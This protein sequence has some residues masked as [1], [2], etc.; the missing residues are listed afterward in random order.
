MAEEVVR[1]KAVLDLTDLQAQLQEAKA[2]LAGALSD[3]GSVSGLPSM[4]S[5]GPAMLAAV[6]G[7][8]SA[9]GKTVHDFSA[10]VMAG[11]A[12]AGA[13]GVAAAGAWMH[14]LPSTPSGEH[15]QYV[16]GQATSPVMHFSGQH[17]IDRVGREAQIRAREDFVRGVVMKNDVAA[18]G[19]GMALGAALGVAGAAV[20]GPVGAI[21][22]YVLGD[23][24]GRKVVGGATDLL[25][26]EERFRQHFMMRDVLDSSINFGGTSAAMSGGVLKP[27]V[28]AALASRLTRRAYET[29][30]IDAGDS[31]T[32]AS[33]AGRSGLLSGA[34]AGANSTGD[35]VE[36]I[37]KRLAELEQRVV[38][39]KRATGS[40]TEGA[41]R[42]IGQGVD[43]GMS[44]AQAEVFAREAPILGRSAGVSARFVTDLSR[45]GSESFRQVGL[46]G[47]A[48]ARS[49]EG[50]LLAARSL[51]DSG[52]YSSEQ[53]MRMGGVEGIAQE[54][55]QKQ[56]G[57]FASDFGGALMIAAG[58]QP[59]LMSQYVSGAVSDREITK[60]A[61]GKLQGAT[62]NEQ[63]RIRMEA[64][65][66]LGQLN[67]I[68]TESILSRQT[69]NKFLT[70]NPKTPVTKE[71]FTAWAYSKGHTAEQSETMYS[72]VIELQ[73]NPDKLT[74][75][76]E[77]HEKEFRTTTKAVEAELAGEELRHDKRREMLENIPGANALRTAR[78]FWFGK[79]ESAAQIET[80]SMS[81]EREYNRRMAEAGD[82]ADRETQN[83]AIVD[84]TKR[85]A[86]E[87][88]QARY[89]A[90]GV[91]ADVGTWLGGADDWFFK[92]MMG[93][94]LTQQ[95]AMNKL[96]DEYTK[97]DG[98]A[99]A[100]AQARQDEY[101]ATAGSQ[102]SVEI[103]R[104]IY[105]TLQQIAENT[106]S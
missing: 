63:A 7:G 37:D 19:G 49:A 51:V 89:R 42:L 58:S 27:E 48:G 54:L 30:A 32:I 22:G 92:K 56:A 103:L 98:K 74:A 28:S 83:S 40:D 72:T 33:F 93:N 35:V 18:L 85:R 78:E 39:L 96:N 17:E 71:T 91:F 43:M 12:A 84:A 55:V 41:L 57:L 102:D 64:A 24:V 52:V 20:G 81:V 44:V 65:K 23:I 73:E 2:Q 1:L 75:Q 50:A 6:G 31:A 38:R 76:A 62:K 86:E 95:W 11:L 5:Y 4:S 79:P 67:P 97:V 105:V 68:L 21:A 82:I 70:E 46:D 16:M 34:A 69:L 66:R 60:M 87:H 106:G 99:D 25:L 101:M 36:S 77:A 104:G 26:D 59:G 100:A 13:A 9:A 90:G 53:V 29:A 14:G 8:I 80:D 3:A 47:Q 45:L 10:P 88:R 61:A 94:D 15:V